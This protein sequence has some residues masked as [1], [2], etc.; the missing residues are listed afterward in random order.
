M[1][2]AKRKCILICLMKYLEFYNKKC[3]P[4]CS[5]SVLHSFVCLYN[6]LLHAYITLYL[7]IYQLMGSCVSTWGLCWIMLLWTLVDTLFCEHMFSILLGTHLE[8]E[9][10]GHMV[11]PYSGFLR[12][13]QADFQRGCI[14]FHSH[15]QCV[16]VPIA[17]HSNKDPSE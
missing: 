9:S 12:N 5:M 3:H 14:V 2:A 7:P 13:C 4:N 17:P 6:I 15:Q 1:K 16:R 11:T 10:L 8:V